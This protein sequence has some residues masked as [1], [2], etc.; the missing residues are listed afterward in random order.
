MYEE[1]FIAHSNHAQ[2]MLVKPDG[3]HIQIQIM[4]IKI[5][6][7]YECGGSILFY[8]LESKKIVHEA[9]SQPCMVK[10]IA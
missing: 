6:M 3:N 10:P 7:L 1:Y 9:F 4:Q 8:S 2:K 5:T